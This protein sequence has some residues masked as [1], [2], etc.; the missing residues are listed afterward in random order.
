MICEGN[1]FLRDHSA[2]I[3]VRE[4]AARRALRGGENAGGA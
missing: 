4:P 3:I 1:D 2:V